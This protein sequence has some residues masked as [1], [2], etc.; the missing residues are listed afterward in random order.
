MI[1]AD[2]RSRT[3][4]RIRADFVGDEY[5]TPPELIAELEAEFGPFELD[6]AATAANA[7]APRY[8]DRD[9]DGLSQPW[10]GR[11]FV[12]PPYGGPGRAGILELWIRKAAAAAD[13]RRARGARAA[14]LDGYRLVARHCLA[15]VDRRPSRG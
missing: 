4:A 2:R 9:V 6:P 13:G 1:A 3:G 8:Y 7:K 10:A 12:N 5:A 14:G 15:A 11:V